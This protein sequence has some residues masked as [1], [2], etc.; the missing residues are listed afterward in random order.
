M[1]R[2][3]RGRGYSHTVVGESRCVRSRADSAETC[4]SMSDTLK[5]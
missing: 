5:E 3:L 1:S 2:R 4:D